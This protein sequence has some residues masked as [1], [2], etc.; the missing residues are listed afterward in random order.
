MQCWL[1]FRE[2]KKLR[3]FFPLFQPNRE[4]ERRR[5]N[6]REDRRENCYTNKCTH[7]QSKWKKIYY[8][9]LIRSSTLLLINFC[10]SSPSSSFSFFLFFFFSFFFHS[11]FSLFSLIRKEMLIKHRTL[12]TMTI[13]VHSF[14]HEIHSSLHCNSRWRKKKKEEKE[15]E[16]KKRGGEKRSDE[17]WM[18]ESK[19]DEKT[20]K[21]RERE[22]GRETNFWTICI[23]RLIIM[24]KKC[25][26]SKEKS[27]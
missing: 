19:K 25:V 1:G 24:G 26:I 21:A 11:F 27:N 15:R 18:R 8:T 3:L 4:G 5:K 23:L 2:K 10:S 6:G 20:N 22:R 13:I 16:K 17:R 14:K 9:M 7:T 12:I